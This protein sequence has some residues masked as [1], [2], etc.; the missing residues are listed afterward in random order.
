MNTRSVLGVVVA[1]VAPALLALP[2]AASADRLPI[3]QHHEVALDS[4]PEVPNVAAPR[5]G[6]LVRLEP[7]TVEVRSE[8]VQATRQEDWLRR[9]LRI[10]RSFNLGGRAR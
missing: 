1:A 4:E 5:G 3:R 6:T 2:N 10:L 8:K 9:V 7:V